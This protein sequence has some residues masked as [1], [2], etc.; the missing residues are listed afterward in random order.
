MEVLKHSAMCGTTCSWFLQDLE[1]EQ[2]REMHLRG[3]GKKGLNASI[4][5]YR[6]MLLIKLGKLK[7]AVKQL[8]TL[9]QLFSRFIGTKI[10]R[11]VSSYPGA[12]ERVPLSRV[13][14]A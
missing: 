3:E 8:K 10:L 11:K 4:L 13:L 5:P 12:W 2:A 7:S 14:A 1:D 9:M 6:N